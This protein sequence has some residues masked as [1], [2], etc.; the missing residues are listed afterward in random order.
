MA[1]A[2]CFGEI[3][4]DIGKGGSL[5]EPR[6]NQVEALDRDWLRAP[7][8]HGG[9]SLD[10]VPYPSERGCPNVEIFGF[11][12]PDA[13]ARKV[14]LIANFLEGCSEKIEPHAPTENIGWPFRQ[15]GD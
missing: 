2:E 9:N 11:N 3:A 12:L 1:I 14:K 8:Q 15:G 7:L 13:F 4:Q 10:E 5:G 6:I